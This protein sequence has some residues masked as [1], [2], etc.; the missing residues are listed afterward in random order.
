LDD[1]DERPAEDDRPLARELPPR[2]AALVLDDRELADD[3]DRPFD[4]ARE[5]PR[6]DDDD[7]PERDL[8]PER[9]FD[10]A[11]EPP[12]S[13]WAFE[14]FAVTRQGRR[15]WSVREQLQRQSEILLTCAPAGQP[16]L[17]ELLLWGLDHKNGRCARF[18]LVVD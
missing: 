6:A 2:A 13:C 16:H 1:E 11:I 10:L 18:P 14:P 9:L 4:P 7:E 17:C 5:P 3:E 12:L 8:E 15:I